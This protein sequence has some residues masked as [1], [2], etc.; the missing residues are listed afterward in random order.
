VT[1]AAPAVAIAIGVLLG[2][3]SLAHHTVK[4]KDLLIDTPV[5]EKYGDAAAHGAVPYRDFRPEYPPAALPVFIL[6]SLLVDRHD[7]DAYGRWF[8]REMAVCACLLVLGIGLITT[9]LPALGVAAAA[10][11]LLGPVVLTRFDYW[12]S[13]LAV[14]GLAA[15][16]RKRATTAAVLLGVAIGA[17]LWPAAIVPVLI[18]HLWR[19][20]GRRAA[21][22][23]TAV[24]VGVVAAIFV[25]F[26]IIA[27]AGIH[28]SFHRQLARPLQ[29]ESL[30]A[31]VLVAVHHLVATTINVDSAFGSQ[32]LYGFGT[33]TVPLLMTLAMLAALLFIWV[34]G[35]DVVAASAASVAAFLAFG[36]V[37]SPQFMIWLV[38]FVPLVPGVWPAAALVTALVLTQA[39]FPAHY[40][41]YVNSLALRETLEVLDRDLL[42]VALLVL[43]TRRAMRP[44]PAP[45]PAS[46]DAAAP[47][48]PAAA[49]HH[50][51]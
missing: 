26:A 49:A 46:A 16:L 34:R 45:Q 41:D 47:E 1:R 43:L 22:A 3:W 28:H 20:H 32:N 37:F 30:G 2:C 18:L 12:P 39:W 35:R 21:A 42:V 4:Q 24:V 40:W 29:V 31:A 51:A 36:K 5:Y 15:F 17:K 11:L 27:P 25:P 7:L 6:P 50:A 10:P 8:D 23:F 44:A 14:L 19:T 33:S 48:H 38:A 13:A 9:R